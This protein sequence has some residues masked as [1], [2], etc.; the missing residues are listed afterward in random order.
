MSAVLSVSMYHFSDTIFIGCV[1][2]DC[3]AILDQWKSITSNRFVLNRV[4]G[5][6]LQ[7][8]CY[9]VIP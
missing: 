7:L 9:P 5:H 4:K 8:G 1:G 2:W 6:N 3:S